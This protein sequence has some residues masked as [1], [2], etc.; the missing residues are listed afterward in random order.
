M[1]SILEYDSNIDGEV[2]ANLNNSDPLIIKSEASNQTNKS[3]NKFLNKKREPSLK[4][5]TTKIFNIAY[6]NIDSCFIF[7]LKNPSIYFRELNNKNLIKLNDKELSFLK[8]K[9]KTLELDL[10][11]SKKNNNF[12]ELDIDTAIEINKYFNFERKKSKIELFVEDK[13][14][15]NKSREDISC[16]KLA[17]LYFDETGEKISKTTI[18]NLIKN[19]LSLSYLKSTVKTSKINNESGVVASFYFIK[20]IIKCLKLGFNIL[21][22]D[23]TSILSCNNNYRCWRGK[24][25]EIF[26][27][28]GT[29]SKRNL[30]LTIS[31]DKIVHYKITEKNTDEAIFMNYMKELYEILCKDNKK[32]YVI[33]MDNLSC[34]R[35]KQM[36]EFYKKN[37]INVIFNVTYKSS[38]NAIELAF[39]TIKFKIYKKLYESIDSVFKDIKDI[40]LEKEF[41][42]SLKKNFIETLYTYLNYYENNRYINLNNYIL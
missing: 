25:E 19:N 34:H 18:N 32:R 29:K 22:L 23:E 4:T 5:K 8:E 9:I 3:E 31:D 13:L 6:I 33:I 42:L 40:L 17:Q 26:F 24:N 20:S 27:N 38:F 11:E 35:T 2:S 30:L 28:L 10:Q 41:S 37:K 14:K 1:K 12:I 39:R 16:R 21:Y 36:F 7:D 15:N